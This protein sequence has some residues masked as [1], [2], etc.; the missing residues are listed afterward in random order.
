MVTAYSTQGLIQSS[1]SRIAPG[2]IPSRTSHSTASATRPSTGPASRITI[3]VRTMTPM[4]ML[5]G[6]SPPPAPSGRAG[7][8]GPR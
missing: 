5:I 6:S 4:T 2:K 3:T 1:R 7:N 8:S